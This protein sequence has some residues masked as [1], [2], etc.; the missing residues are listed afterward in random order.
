MSDKPKVTAT[1][2]QVYRVAIRGTKPEGLRIRQDGGLVSR[3]LDFTIE[4]DISP[5]VSGGMCGGGSFVGYYYE[6]EANRI[7]GWLKGQ[8][9][10]IDGVYT[11]WVEGG[12]NDDVDEE[13]SESDP[14]PDARG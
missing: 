8:G 14:Q 9:V 3:F 1:L 2:H 7:I 5:A 11:K 13:R 12:G 6:P 4:E 10:E